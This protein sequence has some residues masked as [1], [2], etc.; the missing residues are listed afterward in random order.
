MNNI[1]NHTKDRVAI[2][3][4]TLP[5]LIN[6]NGTTF[7]NGTGYMYVKN[8]PDDSDVDSVLEKS[9]TIVVNPND[10]S[11]NYFAIDLLPSETGALEIKK[12]YYKIVLVA[13]DGY[14]RTPII[15]S[16]T[17]VQV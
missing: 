17:I 1:L 11:K 3:G 9:A 5:L 2:K 6:I 13:T 8:E 10:I 4:D 15:G 16:L 14:T 7:L 12:Y